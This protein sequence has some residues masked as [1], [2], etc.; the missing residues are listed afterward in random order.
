MIRKATN[1]WQHLASAARGAISFGPASLLLAFRIAVFLAGWAGCSRTDGRC[2]FVMGFLRS[3]K[4]LVYRE[5]ASAQGTLHPC[6]TLQL[7]PY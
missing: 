4:Y 7:R 5:S 1:T 6:W 2:S 3:H